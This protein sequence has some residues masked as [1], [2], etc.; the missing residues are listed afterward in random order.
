MPDAPEHCCHCLFFSSAWPPW[1]PKQAPEL[2]LHVYSILLSSAQYYI[3]FHLYRLSFLQHKMH[4]GA[5]CVQTVH[6]SSSS[7]ADVALT[8]EPRKTSEADRYVRVAG[9]VMEVGGH[10]LLLQKPDVQRDTL[11][12]SILDQIGYILHVTLMPDVDYAS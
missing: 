8:I 3:H 2:C 12:D 10:C 6:V 5:G 9:V 4:Y 11:M 7:L 1:T